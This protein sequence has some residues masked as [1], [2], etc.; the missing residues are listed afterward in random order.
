M[1]DF[2]H[3]YSFFAYKLAS[4]LASYFIVAGV[5]YFIFYHLLK[6]KWKR[7]KI[8]SKEPVNK[9]LR[10]EILFSTISVMVGAVIQLAVFLLITENYTAIY[11]EIN[12]YGWGYFFLS[13]LLLI[14]I[15]DTYFYWTHWMLHVWTP[16][17][18][19]IHR[20]HHKSTNPTSWASQ[21]FHPAEALI[22][23]GFLPPVLFFIPLH[24]YVISI[25]MAI[26]IL[27]VVYG[28]SGYELFPKWFMNNRLSRYFITST[29]HN[30][31]HQHFH[32]NY[33]LYFMFWDKLMKTTHPDYEKRFNEIKNQQDA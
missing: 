22:L 23:I 33:G 4:S 25:F 32:H 5:A 18:K 21:A 10:H 15:Q 29:H 17:Y 20:I 16:A 31:H 6:K 2:D 12:E 19:F 9:D 7:L 13:L 28:H 8:Q 30:M 14:V 3:W 1:I 11:S 26:N 24:S 27:W